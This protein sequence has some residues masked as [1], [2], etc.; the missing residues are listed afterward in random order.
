MFLFDVAHG[1]A[2]GVIWV[3]LQPTCFPLSS[4]GRIVTALVSLT[5]GLGILLLP[6][7]ACLEILCCS[8]YQYGVV[9]SGLVGFLWSAVVAY[10]AISSRALA[11]HYLEDHG[12]AVILASLAMA[13]PL[14]W[15]VHGTFFA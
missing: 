13:F 11:S 15:V 1:I 2:K 9:E 12:T 8:N 10:T 5:C 6:A 4:R 14:S 7:M 3:L